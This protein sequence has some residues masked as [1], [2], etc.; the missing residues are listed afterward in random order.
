MTPADVPQVVALQR[1]AFPPPFSED[2]HWT[3]GHLLSHLV[4][5]PAGQLVAVVQDQVVGSCSNTLISE[6]NWQRHGSWSQTVGGP[7]LLNFD[8]HGSTL[9]GLDITVHPN[10]RRL[11]IGRAF[12]ERRFEMVRADGR[13]RYGT[14]CRMPDLA[15]HPGISPSEYAFRVSQGQLTDRTLTP[16]LRYGLKLVGVIEGYMEDE[17]SRNVAALLEWPLGEW[18]L[19]ERQP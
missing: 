18:G 4:V 9:Y 10:M 7:H 1:E 17:E 6:E 11:G 13:A 14:G 16:L 19:R 3:E 2:L 5:Y 8:I 12:Y 15:Q